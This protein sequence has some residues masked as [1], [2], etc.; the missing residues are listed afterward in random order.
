VRKEVDDKNYEVLERY[1]ASAEADTKMRYDHVDSKLRT[2]LATNTLAFALMGGFSLLGRPIFLLVALPLIASAVL[3]LRALGVHT[4]QTLSLT[5][6]ELSAE[7]GELRATVLRDRLSAASANA[8]VLDFVVD[9]FRAA[10]RYF[11]AG[12]VMVPLAYLG[13]AFLPPRENPEVRVR[14]LGIEEAI[15]AAVQRVPGPQGPAGPAGPA[16]VPGPAGAACSTPT[17]VPRPAGATEAPPGSSD[18][19]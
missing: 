14:V 16:G 9:S 11:V 19:L 8:C 7:I 15:A 5:D 13:A 4:F 12:L 18:R 17:A 3:G 1:V 2:L 10:H 6:A